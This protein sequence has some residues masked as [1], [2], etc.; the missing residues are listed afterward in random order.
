L[1]PTNAAA[2]FDVE[3]WKPSKL[4]WKWNHDTSSLQ[5][6]LPAYGEIR[7]FW[8]RFVIPCKYVCCFTRVAYFANQAFNCM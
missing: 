7:H 4:A 2:W 6:V 8:C 3:S 5:N 1:R